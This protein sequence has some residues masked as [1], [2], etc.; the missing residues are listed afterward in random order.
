MVTK[1]VVRL[2]RD[3]IGNDYIGGYLRMNEILKVIKSRRSIRSF[4][5]K[6]IKDNEL[7]TVL[8]A[9]QYAP[10]AGSQS[11]QFISYTESRAD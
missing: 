4:S 11:W 8:E 6:Q 1:S 3:K 7:E 10:N 5:D 2:S 9:A